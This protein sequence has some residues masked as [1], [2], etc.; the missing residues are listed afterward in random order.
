MSTMLRALRARF[1]DDIWRRAARLVSAAD[2]DPSGPERRTQ[3]LG[4]LEAE[5]RARPAPPTSKSNL[6]ALEMVVEAALSSPPAA[7]RDLV[8]L[9]LLGSGLCPAAD[10]PRSQ[11]IIAEVCSTATGADLAAF[12]PIK[13]TRKWLIKASA[14]MASEDRPAEAR[15]INAALLAQYPNEQTFVARDLL[16]VRQLD[17]DAAFIQRVLGG[18][19]NYLPLTEI[20]RVF[21]RLGPAAKALVVAISSVP[22]PLAMRLLL[23]LPSLSDASLKKAVIKRW[24][25]LGAVDFLNAFFTVCAADRAPLWKLART[26]FG[27]VGLEILLSAFAQACRKDRENQESSLKALAENPATQKSMLSFFDSLIKEKNEESAK[28]V[29]DFLSRMYSENSTHSYRYLHLVSKT[30]GHRALARNL[31]D[32]RGEFIKIQHVERV[33]SWVN[34]KACGDLLAEGIA[35]IGDRFLV[36]LSLLSS[37]IESEALR[38][39]VRREYASRGSARILAVVLD[40]FKPEIKDSGAIDWQSAAATLEE[41]EPG[42]TSAVTTLMDDDA[43]ADARNASY[44]WFLARGL[45]RWAFVHMKQGELLAGIV[46]LDDLCGNAPPIGSFDFVPDAILTFAPIQPDFLRMHGDRIKD[47]IEYR[48]GIATEEER[49]IGNIQDRSDIDF[50]SNSENG[51]DMVRIA[52]AISHRVVELLVDQEVSKITNELRREVLSLLIEDRIYGSVKIN[53][54]FLSTLKRKAHNKVLIVASKMRVIDAISL[55]I[56]FNHFGV[57]DVRIAFDAISDKEWQ[58]IKYGWARIVENPRQIV[59]RILRERIK[60]EPNPLLIDFPNSIQNSS[61]AINTG[62]DALILTSLG[63]SSYQKTAIGLMKSLTSSCIYFGVLNGANRGSSA[64][65]EA[66]GTSDHIIGFSNSVPINISENVDSAMANFLFK[67]E[68]PENDTDYILIGIIERLVGSVATGFKEELSK[69]LFLT[70]YLRTTPPKCV[71]TLPGRMISA[72]SATLIAR[73]MGLPVIDLQAFYISEHPRYYYS[74]ADTYLGI[75]T[76]QVE[77]YRK[78]T[79]PPT[80]SIHTVGSI[81]ISEQI[82][83]AADTTYESAREMFGVPSG[84]KLIVYAAQNAQGADGDDAVTAVVRAHLQLPGTQLIVKL[85][86]KTPEHDALEITRKISLI[87]TADTVRVTKEGDLYRMMRAA[88]LVL[89]QFSNVGL[90]AAV[91]GLPVIS[92]NF[93]GKDYIVDPF[94]I[95]IAERAESP[96]AIVVKMRELLFDPEKRARLTEKQDAY[97]TLNPMLRRFDV[98]DRIADFIAAQLNGGEDAQLSFAEIVERFDAEAPSTPPPR[99][100]DG[101]AQSDPLV[102]PLAKGNAQSDLEI[103]SPRQRPAF[104]G[105]KRVWRLLPPT[106]QARLLPLARRTKRIL[107]HRQGGSDASH[108][109]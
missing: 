101:A 105:A 48:L 80:Q 45:E 27:Q 68:E 46:S 1:A 69:L 40:I 87:T 92:V 14:R 32:G 11:R 81:M 59:S 21:N 75:T 34:F 4:L 64:L 26:A 82:R 44:Q 96:D 41:I 58:T 37:M 30:E 52:R 72:R 61:S 9:L 31:L 38:E 63:D 10:D 89:T 2:T 5:L 33:L 102:V 60:A 76:D 50:T 104:R 103:Q 93:S 54:S 108:R 12:A 91:L 95:G 42:A 88:D 86:P 28:T 97:F 62:L 67:I 22:S 23:A 39:A 25:R 53:E 56:Y 47:S 57:S 98:A 66:L 99:P 107:A 16:F 84:A 15:I 70:E 65:S 18:S 90:E 6:A 8:S 106:V 109:S 29:A 83:G 94:R 78:K 13:L 17:G 71:V 43:P 85:H 79:P 20:P 19:A 35:G 49:R 77:I 74:L 7:S 55:S 36:R 24:E 100:Q 73:S 51:R 3:A